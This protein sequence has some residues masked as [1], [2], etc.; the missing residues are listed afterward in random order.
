MSIFHLSLKPGAWLHLCPSCGG[1]VR[2][3][4]ILERAPL[5]LCK[6]FPN[7]L[8]SKSNKVIALTWQEDTEDEGRLGRKREECRNHEGR[9]HRLPDYNT[10][11]GQKTRPSYSRFLSGSARRDGQ[12]PG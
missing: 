9:S 4:N 5:W 2:C 10:T 1:G 8:P 7:S 3:I 6:C 11:P 12:Q